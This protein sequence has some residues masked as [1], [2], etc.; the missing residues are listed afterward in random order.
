MNSFSKLHVAL[1][2]IALVWGA[3]QAFQV[4]PT[5][6]T[7]PRIP[8][9]STSS[10]L[11]ALPLDEVA[12]QASFLLSTTG[13]AMSDW[14]TATAA[15]TST[16]ISQASAM[17][18]AAAPGAIDF[19]VWFAPIL[20]YLRGFPL[21]AQFVQDL[22]KIDPTDP[23]YDPSFQP[24]AP[25]WENI[26]EI[27]GGK[28]GVLQH[29]KWG[30]PSLAMYLLASYGFFPGQ[31][32]DLF[33]KA[34]AALVIPAGLTLCYCLLGAFRVLGGLYKQNQQNTALFIATTLIVVTTLP[35]LQLV[36]W[37][38]EYA[39]RPNSSCKLSPRPISCYH[40]LLVLSPT[41]FN[42]TSCRQPLAKVA[43]RL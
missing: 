13:E 41:C 36:T 31:D 28:E 30:S 16:W 1:L 5:A 38:I 10:K 18:A 40:S 35:F 37:E 8:T 21:T 24:V 6:T 27:P 14:T 19:G 29:I 4:S 25:Q 15:T 20:F 22:E 11:H 3:T 43:S 42:G 2:V 26:E 34:S 39:L 32:S 33:L 23:D 12:N 17:A 9:T 7:V